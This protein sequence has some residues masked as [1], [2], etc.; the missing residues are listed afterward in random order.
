MPALQK[1]K[2]S[3]L[4]YYSLTDLPVMMS[5]FPVVVFIPRFYASDVG[6]PLA[7]VGAY[8]FITRLM[9]VVTDPL[10]GYIS[11]HTR[12]RF[13]RRRPWI[14]IATPIMM[15]SIY[16]LFLPP[17]DADGLYMF[18]WM[19]LLSVGTTMMLI[20]Y[21]AWGAELSSDYN[22]RSKVTGWRASLGVVG[23]LTAQVV[24]AIALFFWGIGGS[25]SVLEM[26][27]ITMLVLMPLCVTTT[28][29]KTPEPQ[30]EVKSVVPLMAGL[31]V[32]FSNMAFLRLVGAF[33]IGSI[34]LNITT[35][36]YIFFVATVLGAEDMSIYMLSCFYLTNL[37]T[38][39]F[40]VWLSGKIGKHRAYL[41]S[42]I[43]IA[44][45][46]PFYLFLGEGDFWWML[47]ITVVTGFAAAGFSQAI[48]NSMK[49]D[50]I[51]L[52][53]LQTGENRAAL[54]F[55]AW[56]FAQKAT[57]SIGG[58]IA[59]FGLAL[60]GFDAAP[61]AVND[62]QQMFGLRFLFST[63]P[64]VFFLAAAAI[65]WRYPITEARHAEIRAGLAARE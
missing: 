19:V 21:Y 30:Q 55:S 46:H 1:L 15:L 52:D 63:F 18:I 57:A 44:C 56:S 2:S 37:A 31:K 6:V 62:A 45:A 10:M 28:L 5:I 4:F 22:E 47:P 43:I 34:G 39:P 40:W 27:G 12:S 65:V 13:G 24:P 11:D 51:D 32:M 60:W 61:D 25:A 64:S 42:F 9:D 35:P 16:K 38:I 26:V 50:V 29:I 59:M 8:L 58:A 53:T 36:L 17:A 33:M 20:P 41:A 48:P 7:A 14:A 49:A 3:T 23:Q 54:F